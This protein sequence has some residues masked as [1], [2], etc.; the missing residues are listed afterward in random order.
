MIAIDGDEWT[1]M[2][3]LLATDETY[4]SGTTTTLDHEVGT[5]T[6]TGT[7]ANELAGMEI[8]AV[9]GTVTMN[10]EGTEFGTFVH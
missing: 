8:T 4:D 5:T 10:V 7:Y 3:T 1:V 2:I 9:V 6:V